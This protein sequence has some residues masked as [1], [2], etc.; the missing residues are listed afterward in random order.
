MLWYLLLRRKLGRAA[1]WP[2]LI[3]LACALVM[4]LIIVG[5]YDA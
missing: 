1:V 5:A 3:Y 2:A 4:T